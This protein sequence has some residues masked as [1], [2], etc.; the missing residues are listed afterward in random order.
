MPVFNGRMLV[1]HRLYQRVPN[2]GYGGTESLAGLFMPIYWT[3]IYGGTV[4]RQGYSKR[5]YGAA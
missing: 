2:V 1:Y 5:G 3:T 4:G